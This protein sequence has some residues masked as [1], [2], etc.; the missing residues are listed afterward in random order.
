MLGSPG[1]WI[2]YAASKGAVDTMTVGLAKEVAAEGI[3]VNGVRP[4]LITT[5]IHAMGG[6]PGRVGP[7]GADRA[8]G[9]RPASRPRSRPRSCG[10]CPTRPA[11]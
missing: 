3:R 10:C 2:D 6:E 11:T 8:D 7:H 5:E 1:E 9:A 4:G